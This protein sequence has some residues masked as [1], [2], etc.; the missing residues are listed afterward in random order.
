M[1]NIFAVLAATSAF[2]ALPS[3][4]QQVQDVYVYGAIGQLT[5]DVDKNEIDADVRAITGTQPVSTLDKH[6]TGFKV[7]L[8]FKVHP[9]FAIEAGWNDLG[10]ATYKA[11][12]GSLNLKEDIKASGFSV[13]ALAL[14]PLNRQFTLFG[15]FGTINAKVEA[16]ASATGPGGAAF[17]SESDTSWAPLYG[18]GLMFRVNEKFA[19]RGEYEKFHNLG[20]PNTT[21]EGDVTLLSIGAQFSF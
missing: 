12:V 13:A 8:G 5:F 6:D 4:A 7:G 9:N 2:F 20:D 3:W 1:K 17:V 15:K 16:S 14:V 21:G 10:T 11:T 18:V 19:I